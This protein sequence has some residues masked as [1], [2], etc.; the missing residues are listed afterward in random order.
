M[1][2]GSL[3]T[4]EIS[5][6]DSDREYSSLEEY[7]R[8]VSRWNPPTL[9]QRKQETKTDLS[10]S[11]TSRVLLSSPSLQLQ[12]AAALALPRPDRL[13]NDRQSAAPAPSSSPSPPPASYL[14][15][16]AA[17]RP[18]ASLPPSPPLP[19]SPPP[20]NLP[21]LLATRTRSNADRR[22]RVGPRILAP[23]PRQLVASCREGDDPV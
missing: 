17:S 6:L 16:N 3:F 12:Y 9:P 22:F 14:S 11:W 21:T 4:L 1:P 20:Q 5:L 19:S 7:Q 8:Y 13:L 10:L 2:F 15:S 23:G 18:P